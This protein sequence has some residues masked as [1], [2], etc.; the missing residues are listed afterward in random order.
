MPAKDMGRTAAKQ[1]AFEDV[2]SSLGSQAKDL[3]SS[4][5]GYKSL[6]A[7]QRRSRQHHARG[8]VIGKASK[9]DVSG[10][11]QIV[12]DRVKMAVSQV[13]TLGLSLMMTPETCTIDLWIMFV[14]LT[15]MKSLH[16]RYV[17]MPSLMKR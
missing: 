13:L 10:A 17:F 4:Q 7:V 11:Q 2:L 14:C 9:S 6:S 3:A 1:E 8:R 16:P 5:V 15:R 12:A